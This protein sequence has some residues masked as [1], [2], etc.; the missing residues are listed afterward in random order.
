LGFLIVLNNSIA[1]E[2]EELILKRLYDIEL[3]NEQ[4]ISAIIEEK[5]E[6][7]KYIETSIYDDIIAQGISIV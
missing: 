7:D 3:Q 5:T 6:W 4:V 1:T 2:T